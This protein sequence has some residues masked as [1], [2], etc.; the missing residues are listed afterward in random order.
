MA[1]WKRH[2]K[3]RGRS[4]IAD[5]MAVVRPSSAFELLG[6]EYLREPLGPMQ[7]GSQSAEVA[8]VVESSRKRVS[9]SPQFPAA[10][11]NFTAAH[12]L[13]HAILHEGQGLHR[14]RPL[15]GSQSDWGREP[16]EQEADQFAS[17]FL[18][19]EKVVRQKFRS[20][21]GLN[22]VE[23]ND[24][25]LSAFAPADPDRIRR[26]CRTLRQLARFIAMAEFYGGRHF[27]NLASQFNVSSEA[28]AIRLEELGLVRL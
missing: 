26:R 21:F 20:I 2:Q 18:M 17:F 13:G 8:G 15:D 16:I 3:L 19:P 9:V 4:D 24:D 25:C 27:D 12:E 10:V 6:Y 23:I 14:D 5:P 28:M 1:L 22:C 11:Q 7:V